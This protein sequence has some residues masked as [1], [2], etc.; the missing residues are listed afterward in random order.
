MIFHI[1]RIISLFQT[2]KYF[3]IFHLIDWFSREPRLRLLYQHMSPLYVTADNL[4][5]I[6]SLRCS[7]LKPRTRAVGRVVARKI[8]TYTWSALQARWPNSLFYPPTI[9]AHTN[10]TDAVPIIPSCFR[11]SSA[12][13]L[14]AN[15]H[16]RRIRIALIHPLLALRSSQ[17]L[18]N[19]N[20]EVSLLN[21]CKIYFLFFLPHLSFPHLPCI[22]L[23]F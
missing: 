6:L 2:K 18:S 9:C 15:L 14:R 8:G 7:P 17:V 5:C 3:V 1:S 20:Y 11:Q 21:F 23:A 12:I 16:C 10:Q 4:S 19:N 13:L 22:I